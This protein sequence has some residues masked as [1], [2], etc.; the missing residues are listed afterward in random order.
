[1]KKI[2]QTPAKIDLKVMKTN[3]KILKMTERCKCYDHDD[4]LF[5]KLPLKTASNFQKHLSPNVV[6]METVSQ[7][8]N[9]IPSQIS[10][11]QATFRKTSES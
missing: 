9:D 8:N 3:K 1:M 7:V 10:F 5:K 2:L 6:A 11:W 4:K